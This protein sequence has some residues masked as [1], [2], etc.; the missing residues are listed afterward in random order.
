MVCKPNEEEQAALC[1][2]PC[3]NG[4]KGVGPVCWEKCPDG[5]TECGALCIAHGGSC[6]D[7]VM[8]MMEDVI[9]LAAEI[10]AAAIGFIDIIEIAK[11]AGIVVEDFAHDKCP[12]PAS[13]F[14]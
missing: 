6:S 11:Q 12:D 14:F 4:F 13:I 10:G 5:M 3:K 9:V 7:D 2:D 8:T 1:Y